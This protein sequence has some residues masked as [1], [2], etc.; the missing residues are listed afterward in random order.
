MAEFPAELRPTLETAI[1][2]LV[3]YQDRRYVERYLER[4]RPFAG[5]PELARVV[6]R[7]LAVWMTYDDAIRAAQ[8]KTRASRVERIRRAQGAPRG[9]VVLAHFLNLGPD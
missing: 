8:P 2:R 5:D 9:G 1:A 3:D 4:L 6:A 7:H